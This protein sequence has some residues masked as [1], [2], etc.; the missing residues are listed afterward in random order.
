VNGASEE[1]RYALKWPSRVES[2]WRPEQL[3]EHTLCVLRPL[4]QPLLFAHEAGPVL[5]CNIRVPDSTPKSSHAHPAHP[6]SMHRSDGGANGGDG[7]VGGT[8]GGEGRLDGSN[9]VGGEDGGN[10]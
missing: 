6:A 8:H 9:G 2:C 7:R 4:S 1:K 3:D 10:M 5:L